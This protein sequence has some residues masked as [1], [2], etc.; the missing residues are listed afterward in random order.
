MR[1]LEVLVL[2]T[3]T[4]YVGSMLIGRG[5]RSFDNTHSLVKYERLIFRDVS[6][7][8]HTST[9]FTH[10]CTMLP[11]FTLLSLGTLILLGPEP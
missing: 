6:L 7:V 11:L 4:G 2:A 8:T 9:N 5:Y 3:Y 10:G 1:T